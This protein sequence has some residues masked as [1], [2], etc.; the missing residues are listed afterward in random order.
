MAILPWLVRVLTIPASISFT[1][2]SLTDRAICHLAQSCTRLRY[3][4]LACCPQ[5]TD[6]SVLE[7]ASNLPKL[8]RIGLVRVSIGGEFSK[9]RM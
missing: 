7:L 8:R 3:I 9:V 6:L 1:S 4:D 2:L 5:L